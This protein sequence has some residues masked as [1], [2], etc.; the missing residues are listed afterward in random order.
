MNPPGFW[1]RESAS[2][3]PALLAPAALAYDGLRRLH[4]AT[5][6]PQKAPIPVIC[7][8]AATVGGAGKTP[9]A[10]AIARH[11]LARGHRPAFVTR[12]HGGREAGPLQVDPLRHEAAQTGDEPLLLA[13]I[14]PAWVARD[15]AAGVAAAARAGAGLAILDD[16]L[17]NPHV[18][19][20]LS[21]LVIDGEQ[22]FGNGRLLPAGPL[23]EPVAA[24]LARVQAVLLV[25]ED[26]AGIAARLPPGLP[27]L[28]GR[29]EPAAASVTALRGR[30][31]AAFCGIG[32]PE[33]FR[34]SLGAVGAELTAFR[35]FPDHHRYGEAEIAPFLAHPE[36]LAVTT[37]KDH[38]RLPPGL[39]DHVAVLEIALEVA[40]WSPLEPLL[41]R[42]MRR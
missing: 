22:G 1:R 2:I 18:A 12:G 34:A 23:R 3:L 38:V 27:R 6:R 7:V 36:V 37:A 8:G 16:G 42:T 17:Q 19:K 33:K 20:D 35:A 4:Q 11:L 5:G 15:R 39:R 9:A 28:A 13:A 10:I 25:G 24:A 31:V 40:D 41:A 14:A 30:R 21:I 26:R 29:I 32:A